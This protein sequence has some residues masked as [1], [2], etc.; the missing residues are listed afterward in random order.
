MLSL[1]FLTSKKR[2][3][4]IDKDRYKDTNL[5]TKDS[6]KLSKSTEK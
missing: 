6:L 5:S 1:D 2:Y 3:L 4:D